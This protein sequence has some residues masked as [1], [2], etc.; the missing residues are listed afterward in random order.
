MSKGAPPHCGWAAVNPLKAQIERKGRGRVN[1][2]S[3]LAETSI[4]S[5]HGPYQWPWAFL[6]SGLADRPRLLPTAPRFSGLWSQTKLHHRFC[7]SSLQTAD[8]GISPFPRLREPISIINF[9]S[10]LSINI[11]LV[12]FLWRVLT[13]TLFMDDLKWMFQIKPA[14]ISTIYNMH[15]E[16][17]LAS[18]K[19]AE[20]NMAESLSMVSLEST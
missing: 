14:S 2:L 18:V 15:E 7:A 4:S 16:V 6:V 10:S 13:N 9:L 3:A 20:M 5:Y 8:G 1:S 17:F 19:Q 12:L 11:L